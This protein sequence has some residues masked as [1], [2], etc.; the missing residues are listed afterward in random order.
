MLAKALQQSNSKEA[1]SSWQK[2][3]DYDTDDLPE[4]EVWQLDAIQYLNLKG[5]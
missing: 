2:C 1:Q 4:V 5:K 3:R